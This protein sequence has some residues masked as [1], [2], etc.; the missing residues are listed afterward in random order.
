MP[1]PPKYKSIVDAP[2]EQK[3]KQDSVFDKTVNALLDSNTSKEIIAEVIKRYY[4][5]KLGIVLHKVSD[6]VA[7]KVFKNR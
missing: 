7:I 2:T 1:R 4:F 3:P 6:D 5:E